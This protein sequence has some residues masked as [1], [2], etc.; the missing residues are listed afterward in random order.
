MSVNQPTVLT[1]VLDDKLSHHLRDKTPPA[2]RGG[3]T[4]GGPKLLLNSVLSVCVLLSPLPWPLPSP[5]G[6]LPLCALIPY[7]TSTE[8]IEREGRA[9]GHLPVRTG[10]RCWR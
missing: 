3:D 6:C 8:R 4:G 7:L 1:T 5:Q 9:L 10:R 2:G